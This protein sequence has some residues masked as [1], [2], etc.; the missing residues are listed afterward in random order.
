MADN[1]VLSA[2]LEVKD[3]FTS[4]LNKFK[5]SLNSTETAF[6]KFV[7]KLEKSSSKIEETLDR[8]NKKMDQTSNKIMSQSDKVAN[9][10]IKSTT[11][12]EQSQQKAMDNLL[13]KYTKMGGDV[14]D[15]FKKINKDAEGLSKSGIKLSLG[16][17]GSK[18]SG[19]SSGGGGHNHGGSGS[20][21][22]QETYAFSSLLG[23]DFQMMLMHL[24]ANKLL[25]SLDGLA[26]QGFNALNNISTGLL[27]YDGIKEGLQEAGQFE[28]NRVAMNVLYGNDPVEGQKYYQMGTYLAKK[29]P[30][31]EKEVG[32]LQKKLAGAKL[33]YDKNDLMTLLDI[34]S[35]KPELG[36]EHVGFSIVDSMY[37]RSTSLKTNY[38]LDNKEIQ[39]YLGDLR[40]SKNVE[41]R[42]NAKKWKDAFNVKGTVNNKQ[43]YL[44]L[45]IDYVKKETK[46]SGLTETYSH[47]L[48][49][50]I[51]R[52][53]GNWETL[54]ADLLGIDANNTGMMKTGRIT[55]FSSIEDAIKGLDTWLDDSK[56]ITMLSDMGESLG[57]A[58][59]S[60]TEALK[61]A[62]ENVNWEKVGD[63]F[64]KIG[65]TVGNFIEKLTKDGTLDKLLDLLPSLAE[66]AINNEV[67]KGKTE[68]NVDK[69]LVQ[70]NIVDAGKDKVLGY[71]SQIANYAGGNGADIISY[72]PDE[73]HSILGNWWNNVM[74]QFSSPENNKFTDINAS[75]YLAQNPNLNDVQ[76][77]T[78]QDFI[79][80]DKAPVYNITIHEIKADSFDEIMNSLKQY[81]I[82]KK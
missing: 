58:V 18:S 41:D 77:Q 78:I 26:Q 13:Q 76:R 9:S 42:A 51:D 82:N 40:K 20:L 47:T 2:R 62:L 68:F 38:M 57:K 50:L 64:K 71:V 30:Y 54:K 44:D 74:D 65:D 60:V 35:I 27:S 66:K 63:V 52:L 48:N 8:I 32:E 5:N 25:T 3:S 45:L 81:Q 73:Y 19:S 24:G 23:G 67:I 11:K 59:H 21:S 53:Q 46:F 14:E 33:E 37:G 4:Q 34:A 31:S 36:A 72:N 61:Y 15:I 17:N 69:D 55:V 79:Q 49:G 1:N 16:G 43:E 39:K 70:G 75:T 80:S 28:T 56:T 10:I 22:G 12:V 7:S 29:T 6:N